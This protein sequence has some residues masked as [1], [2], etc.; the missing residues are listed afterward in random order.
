M[1]PR[2][3]G[4]LRAHVTAKNLTLAYGSFV[5]QRDLSFTIRRGEV[6]IIMGGRRLREE[7]PPPA[8]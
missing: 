6:F 5:L 4:T 7:H 1:A 2:K 8:T 3:V